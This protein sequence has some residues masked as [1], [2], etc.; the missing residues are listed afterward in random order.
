MKYASTQELGNEKETFSVPF[1]SVALTSVLFSLLLSW[2]ANLVAEVVGVTAQQQRIIQYAA[3]ILCLDAIVIVPF[4]S[5]RMA[6]KAKRFAVIKLAGIVVNVACNITLLVWYHMGVEGIFLSGVISSVVTLLLLLPTIATSWTL[7]WGGK[8]YEAL[9]RFGLPTVPAGIAAMMIQVID[10]PILEA[11]TNKA[12]VGIYQANYRLG[13]FMMLIVSM[14]DFA[15]RPFFF[16]HAREKEAPQ[17]FARVMTYFLFLMMSVFLVLSLFLEDVVKLPVFWGH[18]IL[19]APYW[20]G[21]SIVPVILLAYVFL[22]VSNNV[23]AGIYIEKKTKYLPLATFAGA[24]VNIAANYLLI[25]HI[26]MMGAAVATLL[27]YAIMAVILYFVAQRFYA[28]PYESGRIYKIVASTLIVFA[29][30]QLVQLGPL[31]IVW[32]FGLLILFGVLLYF[33]RFF[34]AMELK[35]IA[36]AFRRTERD[37]SQVDL[38]AD[39]GK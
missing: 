37:D 4:A 22:G 12:T 38:P 13:I 3:W 31:Q 17:L 18:S 32:K 21:L 16:S 24:G 1:L 29:L 15:W 6:R 23:V 25:P 30:S 27:S 11:L 5:L 28:V 8:L 34:D 7:T 39:T 20:G 19:P 26:G 14:F 2:Q 33:L 35:R 9:L 36:A 10:R